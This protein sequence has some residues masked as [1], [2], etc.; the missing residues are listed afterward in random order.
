MSKGERT[1]EID[2][3]AHCSKHLVEL[4]TVKGFVTIR[5]LR[6]RGRPD[7]N[8]EQSVDDRGRVTLENLDHGRAELSATPGTNNVDHALDP[9]CA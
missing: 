5:R 3:V 6:Q 9:T 4:V 2:E 1:L 7:V 8:V